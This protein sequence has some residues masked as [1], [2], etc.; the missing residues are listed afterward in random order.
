[1]AKFPLIRSGERMRDQS[2]REFTNMSEAAEAAD[3]LTVSDPL[4]LTRRPGAMHLSFNTQWSPE[5][6]EG[7]TPPLV[8]TLPVVLVEEPTAETDSLVVRSVRYA[9][10]VPQ[11]GQ[12]AW[13]GPPFRVYPAIGHRAFDY[14]DAFWNRSSVPTLDATVMTAR[15]A[16][17]FWFVEFSESF[18]KNTS[19][20]T[21]IW[22]AGHS[23]ADLASQNNIICELDP[24][25]MTPR[26]GRF[27]LAPGLGRVSGI[28][29][30]RTTLWVA[31]GG[32]VEAWNKFYKIDAAT[33]TVIG[34]QEAPSH[35]IIHGLGGD[36]EVCWMLARVAGGSEQEI[37]KFNAH[38][39]DTGTFDLL[40]SYPLPIE[41][42]SATTSIGGGV[43]SLYV[44]SDASHLLHV[45]D[46][47]TE[48]WT[49][50]RAL[51]LPTGSVG[52]NTG[53]GG[54]ANTVYFADAD[55]RQSDASVLEHGKW[56]RFDANN[57]RNS[58]MD[59]IDSGVYGRIKPADIG[60]A[61]PA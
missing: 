2:A 5:T 37:F 12:Y 34:E 32:T 28:G 4:Q 17:S 46:P 3:G 25:T 13:A 24:A 19:A 22:L 45:L 59:I 41:L 36:S 8:T 39:T 20:P 14:V 40:Y 23:D 57:I 26:S 1:M 51:F 58:R 30:D 18:I 9:D 42:R 35:F 7:G 55:P 10:P 38:E 54:D 56:W 50:I 31:S 33:M 21:G 60:G 48:T 49:P 52:T 6:Q 16:G 44:T 27:M 43:D 11:E 61:T 15:R 29:G 47:T 53:I